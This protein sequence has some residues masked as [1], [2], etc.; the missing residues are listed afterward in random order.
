MPCLGVPAL[1][2]PSSP[3]EVIRLRGRIGLLVARGAPPED[4]AKARADLALLE[5]RIEKLI[6]AAPPLTAEK[7]ARL[8]ALLDGAA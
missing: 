8:A 5:Q 7:K 1:S 2:T 6:A 4:V 3:N